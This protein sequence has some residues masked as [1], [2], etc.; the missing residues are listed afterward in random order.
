[1]STRK[2][3]ERSRSD[4]L[5]RS[6]CSEHGEVDFQRKVDGKAERAEAGS[7]V[8]AQC[9]RTGNQRGV[10]RWQTI[11]EV[12]NQYRQGKGI[13]HF[14]IAVGV[15]HRTDSPWR[16]C[17]RRSHAGAQ[18]LR[19]NQ[20]AGAGTFLHALSRAGEWEEKDHARDTV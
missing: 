19:E 17:G 6:D 3:D 14:R 18:F 7:S 8:G 20:P 16:T 9:A 15:R 2:S 10:S 13:A 1:E 11:V 5:L 12:G 4:G